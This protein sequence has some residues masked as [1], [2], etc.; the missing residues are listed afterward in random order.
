MKASTEAADS[1][2]A[3]SA[4]LLEPVVVNVKA[5]TQEEHL[6]PA[7]LFFSI[8]ENLWKQN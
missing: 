2:E 6:F 1:W 3:A 7:K 5:R 8:L 4:A